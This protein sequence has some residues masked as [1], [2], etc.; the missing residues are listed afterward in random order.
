[1]QEVKVQKEATMVELMQ[2]M[3]CLEDDCQSARN[4]IQTVEFLLRERKKHL[5]KSDPSLGYQETPDSQSSQE[6]E[7][8]YNIELGNVAQ[9]S[10]GLPRYMNA[11]AYSRI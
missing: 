7:T 11:T 10:V 2:Q 3:R 4:N 6:T 5:A 8:T 1:M 9:G